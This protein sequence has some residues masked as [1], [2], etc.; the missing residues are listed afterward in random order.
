VEFIPG[1]ENETFLM[2]EDQ[3]CVT[4]SDTMADDGV[5][6][7]EHLTALIIESDKRNDDRFRAADLRNEE[8]FRAQGEAVS[9]AMSAAEKAVLKA[10]AAADRRF[11]AVNE[12]RGA[13]NDMVSTLMPRSEAN[14]RFL[15]L[16]EKVEQIMLRLE[17]NEGAGGGL[18][19]GWGYILGAILAAGVI[20]GII[21]GIKP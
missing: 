9:T 17:K 2:T 10:E 19:A 3:I 20:F 16:S 8:R 1:T 11:E 18:R 5:P 12:F 21:A 7:R 6:I 13:L 4:I 15:A 14:Q